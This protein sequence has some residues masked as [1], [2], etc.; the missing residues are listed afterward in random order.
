LELPWTQ[1]RSSGKLFA[2]LFLE[3]A[4]SAASG[5]LFAGAFSR[6]SG[7]KLDFPLGG[8]CIF[9]P[10]RREFPHEDQRS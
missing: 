10:E 9:V 7:K 1:E 2:K 4:E 8:R 3:K 6:K 5:K